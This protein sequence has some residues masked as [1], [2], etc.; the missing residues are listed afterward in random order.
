LKN[1]FSAKAGEINIDVVINVS[2]LNRAITRSEVCINY[3][4]TSDPV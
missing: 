2:M 4:K 1:R 3:I